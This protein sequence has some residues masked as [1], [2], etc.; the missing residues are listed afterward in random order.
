[1]AQ[2]APSGRETVSRVAGGAVAKLILDKYGI[3][4]IAYTVESHGI[5]AKPIDYETAKANY[6]KNNINC[7]DLDVA[8][9]MEEDIL[10]VRKTGETCGG[11]V[12]L[13]V[14]GLPAGLGE[15]VFDKLE[16]T[17]GPTR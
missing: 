3:D 5:K 4:V 13:I 7:P 8:Q 2:G 17:L 9:K 14:R 15:P 10:S 6:R 1:M 16:A 12:E 11:V